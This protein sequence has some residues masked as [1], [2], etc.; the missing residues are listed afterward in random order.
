M[1]VGDMT[2][3]TMATYLPEVWSSLVNV[4]YHTAVVLADL[5]DRRWEPELGVG[6]GDTV[7]IPAFTQ[8]GRS[9]VNKRAT[10]GTGAA[11]TFNYITEGQIQLKADQMAI[12][13][14]RMPVEMS[15]QSMAKYE[16]LLV[17]SA[18]PSIAEQVDYEL[19]SDNTNGLDA[20]TTYVVGADN[21]DVTDDV[22]LE[23]ETNLN[24]VN[25]PLDGRFF[26]MSP[27]TR[28][29]LMQIE[30]IRNQLYN[31]SVGNL[32]GSK[33]QGYMG[34]IYTL[35]C[36]MS[37][38]LEAGTSGKKNAIWHQF[39]IAFAEQQSVKIEKGL[40]IADGLFNEYAAYNVYGFKQIKETFGNEVDGK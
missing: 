15:A 38:N 4:S 37:N 13:A 21:V 36:Y 9:Y 32:E 8:K 27:A 22:I 7:N 39:A 10:F 2:A 17:D 11:L 18:G 40:N 25:A 31:K 20:F 16:K 26:A 23:A 28:A 35:D 30:V 3:T 12:Y 14:F 29:S 6:K 24:N 33:G 19:A 5:M 1:A 34:K